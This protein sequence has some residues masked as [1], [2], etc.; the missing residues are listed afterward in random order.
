MESWTSKKQKYYCF[1]SLCAL[2]AALLAGYLLVLNGS[3]LGKL[4]LGS[5]CREASRGI[6]MRTGP[7]WLTLT[8]LAIIIAFAL[9][10]GCFGLFVKNDK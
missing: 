9:V 1:T 10:V 5:A 3:C 6:L 7:S 4:V 8:D 2:A